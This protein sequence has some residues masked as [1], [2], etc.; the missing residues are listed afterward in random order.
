MIVSSSRTRRAADSRA[1]RVPGRSRWISAIRHARRTR[2]PGRICMSSTASRCRSL[3]TRRSTSGSTPKTRC[4]SIA[5]TP[6]APACRSMGDRSRRA[7]S[8]RCGEALTPTDA[9]IDL[10]KLI[11]KGERNVDTLRQAIRDLGV[12]PLQWGFLS[13][14]ESRPSG[15][16]SFPVCNDRKL[17]KPSR[18]RRVDR[19]I[20]STTRSLVGT[21]VS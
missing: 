20:S 7:S 10:D 11:A 6:P 1:F 19:N 14:H 3:P 12:H 13:T 16:F 9:R 17:T 18:W 21:F 2:R 8:L 4:G 15:R 5:A